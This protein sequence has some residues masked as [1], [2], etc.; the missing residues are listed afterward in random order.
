MGQRLAQP[1]AEE[2][3]HRNRVARDTQRLAHRAKPTQR[4][5]QKELHEHDRIDARP[6]EINIER[7][8][9]RAHRT[10]LDQPLDPPQQLIGRDKL[11]H[12][13]HLKLPRLLTRTHRDRHH[14]P[15]SATEDVIAPKLSS[16]PD[17]PTSLTG[18]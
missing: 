17:S 15:L 12:A 9:R 10:P 1:V 5:D 18:S 4:R 6:A 14:Q 3:P 11:I 13:H 8:S 2:T 16:R 7:G